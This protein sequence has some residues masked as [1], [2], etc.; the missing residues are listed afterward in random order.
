M[1]TN[2]EIYKETVAESGENLARGMRMLADDIEA[3]QGD[4]RLRQTDYSKFAVGEN[5]ALTPGKVI[6]QSEVCQVIQYAPQTETVLRRP[7]LIVPPW[8]NKFYILDLNPQKSFIKWAVDQ[9]HTVFVISWVNPD[10]RHAKKDWNAYA[11]DGIGFALDNV[12][13]VTGETE[14]NAIGYCVGGTL[15]AA[16]LALLAQEG[17]NRIASATLFTTQV[18]FVHAGDLSVFADSENID[19]I[20]ETMKEH[21]YREGSKMATAV[22]MR[23][24]SELSWPYVV[25]N[26][27]RGK[28]PMPVDLLYWNSDSPRMPAANHSYYL[29]N[30]YL[31][32]NLSNDRMVLGG[33]TL[34]LKDVKIPIYNLA[35]REDHIAPAKSVFVGCGSFGGKVTYVMAGSGHIAGVVNPPEKKKYQYWTGGKPVG[36]FDSWVAKAKE[37]EGSWWPHW[38]AWVKKQ[39]DTM[40]DAR[41]PGG[42][43]L[44][45]I[46]D[47]PGS[48]VRVRV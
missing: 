37:H 45:S 10:E 1:L 3:G 29:R 24:A 32:N 48:Y 44:N 6:A 8:I 18:D 25:N 30:C 5:M 21:G 42:G 47:A 41:E 39:D 33:K 35:T 16:T 26:Y 17:D 13:K 40:V 36:D 27:L 14:V 43:K 38:D 4:L 22:N 34:S 9:G 2:P 15:L 23:R 46:E 19:S 12:E 28:E 7:L 11:R 31:E 20:E